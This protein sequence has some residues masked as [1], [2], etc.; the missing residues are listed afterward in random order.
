VRDDVSRRDW[1]AAGHAFV[2]VRDLPE[3]PRYALRRLNR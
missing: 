1:P 3:H 2:D